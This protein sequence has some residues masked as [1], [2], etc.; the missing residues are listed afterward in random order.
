MASISETVGRRV[1]A[2]RAKRCPQESARQ[3]ARRAGVHYVQLNRIEQGHATPQL[4]TLERIAQALDLPLTDLLTD[5][6]A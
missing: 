3:F 4:D 2:L 1:K 5:G 6:A